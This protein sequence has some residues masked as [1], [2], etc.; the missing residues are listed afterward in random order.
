MDASDGIAIG[1]G[2]TIVGEAD[3]LGTFGESLYAEMGSPM[4]VEGWMAKEGHI[5]K[6]WKNRWFVLDGRTIAYFS[7]EGAKQPKGIINMADGTDL[8]VEE[9]YPRP[10]CFTILTPAKRYV[11]QTADDDE[12]AEWIEAIQN[13]L[14]CCAPGQG[15]PGAHWL[16]QRRGCH[17][18]SQS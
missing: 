16:W 5:F 15:A 12:M 18:Q 8:I 17:W 13:N 14:E 10:F 6:T 3:E 2:E 11:L 7:K 4:H 1:A 9:R